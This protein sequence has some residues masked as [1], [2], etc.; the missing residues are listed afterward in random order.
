MSSAESHAAAV[1]AAAAAAAVTARAALEAKGRAVFDH[2]VGAVAAHGHQY[3]PLPEISSRGGG[4]YDT[5]LDKTSEETLEIFNGNVGKLLE[6]LDIPRDDNV[7]ADV[8]NVPREPSPEPGLFR[9]ESTTGP[10]YNLVHSDGTAIVCMNN[11]ARKDK[12][13]KYNPSHC[14]V[15]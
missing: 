13:C 12:L 4:G 15:P 5:R 14:L 9:E 11:V 2:M 8:V 7:D 3:K 10:Y 6:D 1:L